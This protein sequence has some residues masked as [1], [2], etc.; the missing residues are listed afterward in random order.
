M[1]RG[2]T[3]ASK[4]AL[5]RNASAPRKRRVGVDPGQL[6]YQAIV[7]IVAQDGERPRDRAGL[8]RESREAHQ[9]RARDALRRQLPHPAPL[10]WRSGSISCSTSVRAS[11]QSRKG[12]PPLT[13]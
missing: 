12:L 9:D 4:I 5:A 1:K 7:T 2:D 6:G 8:G 13:S 11:S 10:A 3:P